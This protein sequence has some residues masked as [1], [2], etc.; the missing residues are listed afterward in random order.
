M[1]CTMGARDLSRW[2]KEEIVEAAQ[3]RIQELIERDPEM[4][5]D[6]RRALTDTFNRLC[7]LFHIKSKEL[8]HGEEDPR[9]G[10]A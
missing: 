5:Y 9:A 3:L 7:K 1:T 6:E 10:V 8:Q 4:T 2:A